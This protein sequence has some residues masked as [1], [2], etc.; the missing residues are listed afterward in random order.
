[1]GGSRSRDVL[2][3]Q[4][5]DALVDRWD[6]AIVSV[7]SNDVLHLVPVWRFR[8]RLDAII[9]RLVEVSDEVILFGVGDLGTIPRLAFPLNKFAS[10]AGHIADWVH[11]SVARRHQV[12]KIDQ[13]KS[14]TAAFNS[15]LHMFSPDLFHPSPAGHQAWA[16][17]VIPTLESAVERIEHRRESLKRPDMPRPV[18]IPGEATAVNAGSSRRAPGREPA[19]TADASRA[20]ASD[21][22]TV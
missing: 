7:G 21:G 12:S 18:R 1:M 8:R 20:G 16:E 13:W 6:I 17:A 19:A 5:P 22:T 11:R 2:E 4:L 10:G 15:G 9:G 3:Q 14:T